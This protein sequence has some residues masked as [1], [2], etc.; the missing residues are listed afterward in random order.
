MDNKNWPTATVTAEAMH[1]AGE[2]MQ[3]RRDKTWLNAMRRRMAM[4]IQSEM[5]R[6]DGGMA[7]KMYVCVCLCLLMSTFVL[8]VSFIGAFMGIGQRGN[9]RAAME[10][11]HSPHRNLEMPTKH[12][13]M[14][15]H[16]R[17]SA[18]V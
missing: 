16:K 6:L 14:Q 12:T 1:C 9:A 17:T 5:L 13:R 18:H 10:V 3:A 8:T 2:V 15:A 7:I 4:A 11:Q